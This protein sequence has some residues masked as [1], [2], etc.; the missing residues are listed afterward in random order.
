MGNHPLRYK[1]A[2]CARSTARRARP[3]RRRSTRSIAS[4]MAPAGS[5][6]RRRPGGWSSHAGCAACRAALRRRGRLPPMPAERPMPGFGHPARSASIALLAAA[7]VAVVAFSGAACAAT[8]AAPARPGAEARHR[9]V[10]KHARDPAPVIYGRR[11]DAMQLATRI[12][13]DQQLE[14]AWVESTL[15]QARFVPT[16]ARLIAPAAVPAAKNWAAYR[17]RFVEP[18]RIAAGAAFWNANR[19][20]LDAASSRYGVEPAVIVGIVGVETYYGRHL[21]TFRVLDA[22]A[23]LSLDYP[24]AG[25]DRSAFFRAELAAWLALAQHDGLDAVHTLGS[26]AGAIGLG[27]FMPGSILRYAVD[28]DGDGRVDLVDSAADVIGSIAHYLAEHG[29]QAGVP[30]HFEVEPPPDG[31]Q[32]AA[33]LEAD[34]RPTFSAA[35]LG[36]NGARL[37]AA[38]QRYPGLLALVEL[39]N[40]DAAPSYVA[41]S[42]NFYAVTRYNRSSY[43]AMAVIELGQAVLA[44]R[45]VDGL[46][47]EPPSR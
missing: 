45:L 41:G 37:S 4:A 18:E 31:P 15:A 21:G 29:W 36:E 46:D 8:H 26:Y 11:E 44:Q 19:R 40:G 9:A 32:L 1:L 12:A 13:A 17:D 43:Y 22:L 30:T 24:A 27:Q 42:A 16:V 25:A 2:I 14:R 7:V 28:F 34:I 6:C 10:P 33:L 3:R 20:W 38:G 23:T 35:Q 5:G 39:R 47:A